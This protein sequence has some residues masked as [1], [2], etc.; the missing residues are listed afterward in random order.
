MNNLN[1][2]AGILV[3]IWLMNTLYAYCAAIEKLE[4]KVNSLLPL[5][6]FIIFSLAGFLRLRC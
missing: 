5:Q 1:I 6:L 2:I 4:E 3:V